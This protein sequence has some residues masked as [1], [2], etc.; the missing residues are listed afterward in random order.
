MGTASVPVPVSLIDCVAGL[1]FSA[2]S[3]STTSLAIRPP[4]A[5]V[6]LMLRLQLAP[7]ASEKLLVQSSGVPGPATCVKL[8]PAGGRVRPGAMA[9]ND[10]L[11]MFCTATDS[12]LSVLISP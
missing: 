1:A 4:A 2:L 5:G 6:K 9:I 11:P 7:A 3:V 12:G 8:E 10:W